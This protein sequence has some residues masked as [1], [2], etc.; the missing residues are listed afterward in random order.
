MRPDEPAAR[1]RAPWDW[2]STWLRR[3]G[4]NV[5][6]AARNSKRRN[7]RSAAAAD[8]TRRQLET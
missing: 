6:D 2:Q 7:L 5:V 1:L 3:K 4:Q 8:I